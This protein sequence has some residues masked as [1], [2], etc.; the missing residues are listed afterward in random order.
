M[1]KLI[2]FSIVVL[3]FIRKWH[4]GNQLKFLPLQHGFDHYYGVPYSVD[5]GATVWLMH[6]GVWSWPP[7]PI[8][9]NN[10][11]IEQPADLTKLATKYASE[12]I[13]FIE[14]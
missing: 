13:N 4:L 3:L 6:H 12:A 1:H 14:N 5:M 7:L 9:R 11:V 10:T 8:L 2:L